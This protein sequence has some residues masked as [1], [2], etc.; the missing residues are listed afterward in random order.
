MWPALGLMSDSMYFK[1]RSTIGSSGPTLPVW[2]TPVSTMP[3][4]P[5]CCLPPQLPSAFCVRRR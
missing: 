5:I 3:V 2:S 4:V 1:P